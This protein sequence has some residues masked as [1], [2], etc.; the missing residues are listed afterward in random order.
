MFS[1]WILIF[2]IL[3]LIANIL[4]LGLSVKFY[5]EYFKDRAI[6]DRKENSHGIIRKDERA[7]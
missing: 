5:T 2:N 6:R 7:A 3:I 4:V 1:F